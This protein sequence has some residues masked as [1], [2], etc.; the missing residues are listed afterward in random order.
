MTID[1][2]PL[3][4]NTPCGLSDWAPRTMTAAET[5]AAGMAIASCEAMGIDPRTANSVDCQLV[6]SDLASGSLGSLLLPGQGIDTAKVATLLAKVA[7]PATDKA[8]D[9]AFVASLFADTFRAGPWHRNPLSPCPECGH[10]ADHGCSRNCPSRDNGG[11][12]NV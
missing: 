9:R 12:P 11:S 10:N 7:F 5:I 1:T 2:T 8:R 6:A 3:P 4:E